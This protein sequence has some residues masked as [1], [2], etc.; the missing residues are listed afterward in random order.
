MKKF[1]SI[2]L[3]VVLMFSLSI[4]VSAANPSP[5][6]DPLINTPCTGGNGK[7]Q[8]LSSG[9]GSVYDANSRDLIFNGAC[10]QCINC[11]MVIVTEGDPLQNQKILRYA[12]KH[13][14]D[15][16]SGN[17][18]IMYVSSSSVGYCSTNRLEGYVF[19]YH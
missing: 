15:P 9:W 10:W 11:N 4:G 1:I 13:Y 2:F 7:C 16:V 17:G 5:D 12:M 6:V 19:L 8:M 18:C 3:C 14:V